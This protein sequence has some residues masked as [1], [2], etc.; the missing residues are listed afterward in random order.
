MAKILKI[1]MFYEEVEGGTQAAQLVADNP[2]K[3]V[4]SFSVQNVS[5]PDIFDGWLAL[6]AFLM[7][8]IPA[9][10]VAGAMVRTVG[11]FGGGTLD[12]PAEKATLQLADSSVPN[13]TAD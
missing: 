6:A 3:C 12:K 11:L 10:N 9:E 2:D 13:S 5:V 4:T 8:Q 7:R 1:S